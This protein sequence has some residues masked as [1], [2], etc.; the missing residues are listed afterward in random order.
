MRLCRPLQMHILSLR[1][2]LYLSIRRRTRPSRLHC[3]AWTRSAH[4][5]LQPLML[6]SGVLLL[7]YMQLLLQHL[8]LLLQASLLLHVLLD[9][10]FLLLILGTHGQLLLHN[11]LLL[12]HLHLH[13]VYLLQHLLHCR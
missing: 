7:F 1:L 5:R 13:D 2:S 10:L 12:L 8:Y 11:Q 6:R 9:L 4:A 3:T